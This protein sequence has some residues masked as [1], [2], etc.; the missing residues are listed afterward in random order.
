MVAEC[1]RRILAL[2]TGESVADMERA[3]ADMAKEYADDFD[4]EE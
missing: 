1:P 2:G 3:V 4:E